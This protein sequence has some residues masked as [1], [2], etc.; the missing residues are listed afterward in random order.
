VQVV[1]SEVVHS[2]ERGELS[3]FAV[4]RDVLGERA[5]LL[6]IGA[7]LMLANL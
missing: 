5:A 3:G 6:V 4:A 7:A 2:V 1:A